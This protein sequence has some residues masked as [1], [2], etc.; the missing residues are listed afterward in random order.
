MSYRTAINRV[1]LVFLIL[2]ILVG[3]SFISITPRPFFK[4]IVINILSNLQIGFEAVCGSV[5]VMV[6][7]LSV[8]GGYKT[9]G[10][11]SS[12]VV[13]SCLVSARFGEGVVINELKGVEVVTAGKLSSG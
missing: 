7:V 2:R 6:F 3:L 13:G 4:F 8:G 10:F 5:L 1:R 9:N 11:K 12:V